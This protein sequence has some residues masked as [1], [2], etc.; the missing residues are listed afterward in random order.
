MKPCKCSYCGKRR[1]PAARD[2]HGAIVCV[3][4]AIALLLTCPTPL[5]T[6]KG[7]RS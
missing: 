1:Q 2:W 5:T 7:G 4:C 6:T 3:K